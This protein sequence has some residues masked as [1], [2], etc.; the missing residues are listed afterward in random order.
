MTWDTEWREALEVTSANI[1]TSLQAGIREREAAAAHF[2][3]WE[4]EQA[5]WWDGGAR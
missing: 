3:A 2:A 4:L 5:A 1:V